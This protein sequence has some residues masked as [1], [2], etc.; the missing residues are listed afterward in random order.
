MQ[1]HIS[2][3]NVEASQSPQIQQPHHSSNTVVASLPEFDENK[4]TF[5][6]YRARLEN[7][8][9]IH[10]IPADSDQKNDRA[11][12]LLHCIGPQYFLILSSLCAPE[13]PTT[14]TY[15]YLMNL[16]GQHIMLKPGPLME[17][18][19]FF[20]RS[21][22]SSETISQY[23]TELKKFIPTCQFACPKCE[24]PIPEM[25]LRIQFIRGIKDS[26]IPEKLLQEEQENFS[27]LV[28][29]ANAYE[30]S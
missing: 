29:R 7:S 15:D 14:K 6:N 27:E 1:T 19:R 22:K 3:A 18:N 25:F 26:Y 16:L 28:T 21:Q 9:V 11:R 4:E 13:D 5:G 24:E 10:G 2:N 30:A 23:L 20:Q 17:Q 12:L 8:F